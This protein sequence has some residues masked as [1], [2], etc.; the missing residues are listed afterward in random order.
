MGSGSP[1]G[2]EKRSSLEKQVLSVLLEG[3]KSKYSLVFREMK[4]PFPWPRH[5]HKVSAN[6]TTPGTHSGYEKLNKTHRVFSHHRHALL[7]PISLCLDICTLPASS[8]HGRL[9][10]AIACDIRGVI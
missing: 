8:I 1:Q 5:R 2:C 7:I 3:I 6:T 10:D 4:G 9:E